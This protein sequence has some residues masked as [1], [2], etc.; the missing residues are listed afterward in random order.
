MPSPPSRELFFYP[1]L[2]SDGNR[3]RLLVDG[4]EAFPRMLEAISRARHSVLVE[5]YTF[6]SDKTGQKFADALIERAKA[7]LTVRVLY[8]GLGSIE[9]STSMFQA[10]RAAGAIVTPYRPINWFSYRRRDHRK[11]V[12]VDGSVAFLGGMNF[13]D[14]YAS[15]ADGGLGW[16]DVQI[17]ID[18]PEVRDLVT[19]FAQTWVQ[20]EDDPL[21]PQG[22]PPSPVTHPEGALVAAIGSDHRRNRKAIGKA[23]L[24]AIQKA[25]SRIW[26]S[27]A[28]FVPSL[29][30]HRALRYAARRGVDVRVLAPVK[31]DVMPVYHASR[32]LFD[33][34]LRRGV[35]IFEFQGPVL[36]AKTT[37]IDGLWGAVGSYNLDNLSL[38][39]NLEVAGIV[40]DKGFA[41]QME[42]LFE[43]DCLNSKEVTLAEWERRGLKRR[44]LEQFWFLFRSF[45]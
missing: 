11:I 44:L 7:G 27:N 45:L 4:A 5:M 37:V 10:I 6:A 9:A 38:M 21:F 18:G 1:A 13:T 40:M 30:I 29:R 26:I 12:I 14:E 42:S 19:L 20:E 17:E 34:L 16:H 39:R 3:V 2:L 15:E 41:G 22:W 28:Y 23:Y 8:D 25:R 43:K 35:R 32:A 24:H 36:H 31:T 33:G